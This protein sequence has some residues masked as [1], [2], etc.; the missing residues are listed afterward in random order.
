MRDYDRGYV[1]GKQDR[2]EGHR[3]DLADDGDYQR[4]YLDGW[5]QADAVIEDRKPLVGRG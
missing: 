2:I 5:T 3:K 4:G 1:T